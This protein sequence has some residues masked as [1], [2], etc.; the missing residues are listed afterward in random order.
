[1]Q[2]PTLDALVASGIELDRNYVYKYCSPTR[3]ALQS[4]RNPYHVN[5]LNLE[6]TANNPKDPVAGFAAIPRNMTG[7]ATK[8]AAGGYKTAAFGKWDAGMATLDHTPHGRGYHTA[9]NYFHHCNDYWSFDIGICKN[10]G[11]PFKPIPMADLW[12]KTPDGEEGPAWGLNNRNCTGQNPNGA[13][14]S[15]CKPSAKGGDDWYGGYEDSLF[16][17]HGMA[18]LAPPLSLSLSLS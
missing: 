6:P 4:G 5:P 2:T 10:K 14:P 3:S 8:M 15:K 13:R 18:S 12:G 1:M 9:L 16:E 11:H 7:I 17:Q